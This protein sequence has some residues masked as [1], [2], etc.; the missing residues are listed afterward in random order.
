MSTKLLKIAAFILL[1]YAF[2]SLPF[3]FF[4]DD[5]YPRIDHIEQQLDKLKLDN[6]KTRWQIK[7]MQKLVTDLRSNSVLIKRVAR[8]EF[9]YI[10]E[11]EV[12][13]IIR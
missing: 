11:N 8:Q 3:I 5:N 2:I 9:G 1:S 13:F 7:E 12:I 4:G 6:Q 10:S